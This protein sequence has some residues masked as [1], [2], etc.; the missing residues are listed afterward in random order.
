MKLFAKQTL[1]VAAVIC[2]ALLM[3]FGVYESTSMFFG[4]G[5]PSVAMWSDSDDPASMQAGSLVKKDGEDFRILLFSDIQLAGNPIENAMALKMAEDLARDTNPDFIM[6]T[7]DNASWFLS[8]IMTKTVIRKMESLDIPWGVVLGNHDS[9]WIADRN[10]TGNR[11]ELA[12][13]SLFQ[14]GPA[15]IHGVGNYVVNILDEKGMRIYSLIMLD[16]NEYRTYEDGRDY[17]FIYYDQIKWYEWIV[18]GQDDVPSM[19]FFHIPLPEFKEAWQMWE[20]GEID[21]SLGFGDNREDIFCAPVNTGLF[22]KAKELGNTTHIFCGHDH[23]NNLSVEFDGI[24]LTYGLKTGPSSYS[25]KDRQG[26]TLIT[27]LDGSNEV[28]VGHIY[29]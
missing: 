28:T 15:N 20:S 5:M 8:G 14:M 10:W 4:K 17:D 27:I 12:K 1:K 19:L 25:D 29:Y 2:G 21:G 22:D 18:S 16:S 7:G 24:R 3:L 9:E 26:A 13:N 11:Y 23:I 6:T